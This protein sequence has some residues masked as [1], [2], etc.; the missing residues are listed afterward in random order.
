MR[1]KNIN[2]S[3]QIDCSHNYSIRALYVYHRRFDLLP[4][5]RVA[6]LKGVLSMRI[7]KFDLNSFAKL[8]LEHYLCLICIKWYFIITENVH[9]RRH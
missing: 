5:T 4:R 6:R 1:L 9:R 3:T 8:K 2:S 7:E